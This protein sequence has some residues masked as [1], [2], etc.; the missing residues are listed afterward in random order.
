MIPL[1]VRACIKSKPAR[2]SSSKLPL[3]SKPPVYSNPSVG[4]TTKLKSSRSDVAIPAFGFID[5]CF[6]V[7]A[8]GSMSS[9][10]AQ[11]QSTI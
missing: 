2:K 6:C 11:V 9:E 7:D 5:V 4:K 8:T 3:V 10:I 1:P